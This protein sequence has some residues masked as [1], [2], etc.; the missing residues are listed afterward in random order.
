MI[1]MLRADPYQT[2]ILFCIDAS[3]NQINDYLKRVLGSSPEH[4]KEVRQSLE[5]MKDGRTVYFEGKG[6]IVV[7]RHKVLGAKTMA[8]L[9]HE[10]YHAV[11]YILQSRGIDPSDETE[12]VYAYLNQDLCEKAFRRI[13]NKWWK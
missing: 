9:V 7:L 10:I 2:G 1:F 6:A 13:G 4:I 8:L 12:E 3:Q 5:G 11:S